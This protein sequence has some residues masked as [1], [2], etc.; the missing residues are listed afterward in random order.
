M[1]TMPNK[2]S[3]I[4]LDGIDGSGTTTQTKWL[5]AALRERFPTR[6][7]VQTAEPTTEVVG[8]HIRDIFEGRAGMALPPWDVMARLFVAD[9]GL[10]MYTKVQPALDRGAIVVSDRYYYSTFA[11]QLAQYIHSPNGVTEYFTKIVSKTL[12]DLCTL[13]GPPTLALILVVPVNVAFERR[14]GRAPDEFEKNLDYQHT[15]ASE[16]AKFGISH[17]FASNLHYIDSN[18]PH[19]LV[20]ADI[21]EKVLSVLTA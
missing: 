11:Y 14:K 21:I 18:R 15:V 19:E 13:D 2:G 1:K 10:H 4:V 7:I 9:R 20:A 3:F 12:E 6:E 5:V 16:Y 17:K 8:K